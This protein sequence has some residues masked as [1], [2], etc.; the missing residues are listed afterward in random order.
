[1]ISLYLQ[2]LFVLLKRLVIVFLIYQFC[3]LLFYLA[4]LSYFRS[5][6]FFDVLMDCFFGLRT[7]AFSIVVSNSLFILLSLMPFNF[8][9]SRPYQLILKWLYGIGNSVFIAVNCIDI[10]YFPFIRKRSSA[11][12]LKQMGGQSDMLSLIPRFVLDFWWTLLFFILL[13]WLMFRFYKRIKLPPKQA[14]TLSKPLQWLFIVLIFIVSSG[15][16]VIAVRGGLQRVPITIV[17]AGAATKSEEVPIVLNT[18]FTI[19]KSMEDKSL[20]EYNF[21]PQ[22]E[23]RSIYDPQRHYKDLVFKKQNV[24]VLILESFAKEY[25]KLGRK[26]YTPFLDSLMDVSLVCNNAFSNGS[27]SIEGIPA[28][29]SSLPS[30]MENPFIN[31]LYSLNDQTSLATILTAE[32]YQTAFFHGGINGT[33]NFDAWA[34]LAGYGAY[35]GRNEYGNDEDFDNFWGI[36]D[37]PFLKYS[38]KKMTEFKQPFHSA[39]FTLS[40]HHPYKVPEK[41]KNKFPKGDLENSESIGYADYSLRLFFQA[42]KKTDWYKNTLFVLTADHGSL[43]VDKFF[44]NVVGNQTI[45][46]LFFRPDNS[47]K[48]IHSR[49]FSQIDILP[50]VLQLLGYNKPFFSFGES[51][52]EKPGNDYFYA[53]ATHYLF[54]DSMV[55]C[56]NVPKLSQVLKYTTDSTL[57]TNVSNYYPSLDTLNTRGFKAFIQTYNYTLLHNKGRI[58]NK[59][60]K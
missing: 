54:G 49:V 42:A 6:G 60:S 3:R 19:I 44:S 17:D 8:F 40:S 16:A 7:D 48:G 27:K 11:D 51:L 13:V 1:M 37:E 12:L 31:S 38:V 24:V 41:Y 26:S 20:E 28:I 21:Y 2:Q 32:G 53:S 39:I 29:L 23:L 52:L 25:T 35:Y 56:F 33:M 14:Y 55:Y 46:I 47:M 4:N 18:P 36:W 43:S 5:A 58:N 59:F 15:L 34:S 45:P 30:L 22:E 10:G 9:W 57:T 50:S